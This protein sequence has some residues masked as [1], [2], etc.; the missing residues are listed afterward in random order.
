MH[1]NIGPMDCAVRLALGGL[2][3]GLFLFVDGPVQWVG[4]LGVWP[5]ATGL[6]RWCPFYATVGIDT[7][8]HR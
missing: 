1:T 8:P 2:L 6:M 7:L 3:L 5:L 4:M